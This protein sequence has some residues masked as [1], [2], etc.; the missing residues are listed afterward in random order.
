GRHIAP[1]NAGDGSGTAGDA[2]GP[3]ADGYLEGI[4]AGADAVCARRR[5]G[6]NGER[7]ALEVADLGSGQTSKVAHEDA[8]RGGHI[9]LYLDAAGIAGAGDIDCA[10]RRDATWEEGDKRGAGLCT[11]RSSGEDHRLN[12]YGQT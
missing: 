2:E 5:A 11:A 1:G 10:A 9:D 6:G 12:D 4:G 8:C 3:L 7:D